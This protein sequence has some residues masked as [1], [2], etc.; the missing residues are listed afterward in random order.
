MGAVP[1]LS[2]QK[3]VELRDGSFHVA[4]SERTGAVV[5]LERSGDPE[6]PN[7]VLSPDLHPEFSVP[8]SRWFG[9]LVLRY[10]IGNGAWQHA[11]TAASS[12]M[13]H[14]VRENGGTSQR[15]AI[16]YT[17]TSD[18]TD[19]IKGIELTESY[20]LREGALI[21]RIIL[22][23]K[24]TSRV[25]IGDLGLPLLFN[26]Y[27]TKDPITTYTRRV[28]RHS[29]IEGDDSYIFWMRPDGAGPFLLMTPAPGTH[30]EYYNAHTNGDRADAP[31]PVFARRGA[32]EGLYTAYIHAKVQATEYDQGGSWRQPLTSK[33]LSPG[34]QVGSD[35][36]YQFAF[37]WETSYA[38]IREE[39]V[40]T[41]LLDI[42]VAPGMVIPTDLD[43][44]FSLRSRQPA[45]SV[46]AE[47]PS[48]TAIDK[49]SS[50]D[51]SR[52]TY[53]VRFRHLGENLITIHFGKGRR[54]ELEFFVTEPIAILIKKRAAFIVRNQQVR[55]KSKWYDGD[56]SLWDM[57]SHSFRTP[58]NTGD[59]DPYMVGGSDDPDLCKAPYIAAKNVLYPSKKEIEALEYYIDNFV[60]G[61][62]QRTDSESPFPFGIYGTPSWYVLRNGETGLDSG[63]NG[64]EHM[65][66][67]F[68]YTHVIQLYFEMYQIAKLYPHLVQHASA[69]EYLERAYRTAKAFFE[70]PYQIKMGAPWDFRGWT[71]WAYKQGN[72]HEVFILDLIDA[73]G[74]EGRNTEAQSL[75]VEWEKKVL[76]FLYDHPFPFGSEMYF[77]TTAFESTHAIA[78]FAAT[79]A[80]DPREAA[81]ADKN[82]GQLYEHSSVKPE[83]VTR[84]TQNEIRANVAARG[85]IESTYF[86][87]GSDIRQGG[88]S[89]YLLSYMTQMGGWSI[90]DYALKEPYKRI[91]LLRLG[92]SSYLAG[93]TDVNSGVPASNYGFWFPGEENDGAAGWAFNPQKVGFTWISH[94]GEI[95]RGLWPYDG[96]IDSGF[97][98][99]IRA[100]SV[101]VIRDPI[102][103][104]IAYGGNVVRRKGAYHILCMDGVQQRVYMFVLQSPVGITL[105][106]NHF[107]SSRA[108]TINESA[109]EV[110]VPID[111]TD[112][113]PSATPLTITGLQA[114]DYD[115]SVDGKV[116]EHVRV[117]SG[118]D[119][120]V[121][122]DLQDAGLHD[123]TIRRAEPRR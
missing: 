118:K 33:V 70:V 97:S 11:T 53:T 62:L 80:F 28:I 15:I 43:G 81:W 76:Y 49:E 21:W 18:A 9:D 93:W 19:A 72:F 98:G 56:F 82:T 16:D 60:W 86:Q 112:P 121:S 106:A 71:D 55:D 99:S 94:E 101:L 46:K 54:T 39:L 42:D 119:L 8:D 36:T 51:P 63:G 58:D 95:R 69:T 4:V 84:F 77:D 108:L 48:Q 1:Y 78:K 14:V 113:A 26:T 37:H 96:E 90:L 68:D 57:R 123:V 40:R 64:R 10:R 50:S 3:T 88:D 91:D 85:N 17:G 67:T 109:S 23:N 114:G 12:S 115:V 66:R 74:F 92:Y 34:G 13:R 44:H 45:T 102:F 107:S 120:D 65:W 7:F 6:S 27:Y 116:T 5:L 104:L 105:G 75:R 122:C 30:L 32:W 100:A 59:L 73:L 38:D 61:K 47:F 29:Y 110:M 87:L 35:V 20:E 22:R 25:E 111:V 2:A 41:G 103:G 52:T 24:S 79:N 89:N 83:D 31:N 117:I